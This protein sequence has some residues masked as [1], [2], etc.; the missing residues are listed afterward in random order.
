MYSHLTNLD[1][2]LTN[3]EELQIRGLGCVPRFAFDSVCLYLLFP[4]HVRPHILGNHS[5]ELDPHVETPP[6]E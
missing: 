6:L 3:Q 4:P 1:K 5:V 2:S